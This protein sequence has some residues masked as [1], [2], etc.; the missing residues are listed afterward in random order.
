[1]AE[2]KVLVHGV[3]DVWHVGHLIHL[4]KAKEYGTRLIVSVTSDRWV[5][6]GPGRPLFNEGQRMEMMAALK[7]VDNVILSDH[8]NAVAVINIVRCSIFAKG[9]DYLHGDK[10]GNLDKERA[11]VE[12]VG[13]RLVIITNDIV[14][15]STEIITG[16]LLRRRIREAAPKLRGVGDGDYGVE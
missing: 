10:T 5:C 9:P 4:R 15:S 12:A 3:W 13:G 1:M 2:K 14:Y 7:I 16:E 8:E 11:A 6:K